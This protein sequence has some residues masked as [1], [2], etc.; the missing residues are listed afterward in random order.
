MGHLA[1]HGASLRVCSHLLCGRIP[2]DVFRL[3]HSETLCG[4]FSDLPWPSRKRNAKQMA[5]ADRDQRE[6]AMVA[7]TKAAT[8]ATTAALWEGEKH[9]RI[10][11]C[12]KRGDLRAFIG[13]TRSRVW[14]KAIE[15]SLQSSVDSF[16]FCFVFRGRCGEAQQRYRGST[17]SPLSSKETN[18]KAATV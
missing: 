18:K 2:L 17:S 13:P 14:C 6:G 8:I 3:I 15:H 1:F 16:L 11:T 5:A 12:A 4:A 10:K 9:I 7:N